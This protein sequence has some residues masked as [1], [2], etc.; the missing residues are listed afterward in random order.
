VVAE[1]V[2]EGGLDVPDRQAADEGGDHERFEGIGLGDVTA[3]QTGGERLGG[4]AQL[5]PGQGDGPGGGL[6]GHLP[7][8]VAA[9]RPGICGRRRAGIA[10]TAEEPGDLGF[11]SG[12]HQQLRAEPGNV[13]EDLR[14][15]PALSE[16]LVNV[17]MDT[18]C[19]R[20]SN[21]HG[22]RSFLR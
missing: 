17:V 15:R 13:L 14:Q 4:A 2:G 7:V 12:L 11:E 9:A 10:V 21:R 1:R 6:D 19:R 5:R 16:Q 18:V 8:A 20:Y 3:E 22:R